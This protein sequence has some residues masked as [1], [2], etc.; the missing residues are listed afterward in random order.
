LRSQNYII[1]FYESLIVQFRAAIGTELV[2]LGDGGAAH[3]AKLCV[4]AG[5]FGS[6]ARTRTLHNLAFDF[7]DFF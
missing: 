7:I 1:P 4:G 3:P 5:V 2:L 6:F